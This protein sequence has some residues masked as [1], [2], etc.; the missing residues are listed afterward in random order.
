MNPKA[1]NPRMPSPTNMA[2]TIRTI[3]TAL[4]VDLAGGAAG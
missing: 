4:V 1:P 3:F 2:T